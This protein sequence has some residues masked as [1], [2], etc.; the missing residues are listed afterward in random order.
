MLF[1]FIQEISHIIPSAKFKSLDY[2][3]SRLNS[4]EMSSLLPLIGEKLL[5]Q[6]RTDYNALSQTNGGGSEHGGGIWANSNWSPEEEVKIEILRTAQEVLLYS[7]LCNHSAILQSSF[8]QG[9]GWNK[10]STDDYDALDPKDNERLDKD[11]WHSARRAKENLL[12]YLEMDARH[13]RVYTEKWKESDYYS[14]HSDLL[15]TTPSELHP[16]YINL[17]DCPHLNFQAYVSILH[18]CQDG[19]IAGSIGYP[20][21]QA[22]IDKKYQRNPDI[23]SSRDN[24]ESATAPDGSAVGEEW[25]SLDRHVRTAL[26]NFA[27]YEKQGAKQSLDHL[28]HRGKSQLTL[29]V[30]YVHD[31]YD[32]FLPY[33]PIGSPLYDPAIDPRNKE[34]QNP[35]TTESRNNAK[36]PNPPHCP[37]PPHRGTVFSMLN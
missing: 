13:L 18:D 35:D 29:A 23:T 20:L 12:L 8:N 28:L 26:A 15:F 21:L 3:I 33:I 32:D 6:L 14:I 10:P 17:G 9:G 25:Q 34:Q 16:L 4:E 22:L 27:E 30:K 31:H 11:L 19:Y 37:P 7:Y 2:I 5:E 36:H 24:A 1:Q